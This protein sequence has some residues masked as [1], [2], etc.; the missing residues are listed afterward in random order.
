MIFWTKFL[1]AIGLCF[2][3]FGTAAL[4]LITIEDQ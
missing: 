4:I 3:V 1:G 2:L